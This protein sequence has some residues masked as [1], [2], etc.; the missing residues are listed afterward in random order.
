ME[1][2]KQIII[3]K[4]VGR[5]SNNILLFSVCSK[6]KIFMQKEYRFIYARVL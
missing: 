6:N 5:P 3:I 2:Y 4:A 1:I